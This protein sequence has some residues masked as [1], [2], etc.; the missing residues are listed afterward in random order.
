[1]IVLT[2]PQFADCIG[3]TFEAAASW[4]QHVLDAM[5]RFGITTRVRVAAFL[6][7]VGHESASLSRVE[8][9]LNYSAQR[10]M[11]VWPRRFPT[12]DRAHYFEHAPERLAN[13]VYA[14]R[15]GNAGEA[16][17]DGWR[18]RGRGPLQITGATN[19]RRCGAALTKPVW[20]YP[21]LV[22]HDQRIGAL[23]AGWVWEEHDCNECAA[24]VDEVSDRINLG[25][26]T[27]REGD[28]NGFADRKRRFEQAMEVIR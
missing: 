28:A 6:A 21:D 5:D 3:C 14:N 8:E 18:Y 24:D 19:Y 12:I 26:P 17:G 2:L 15:L 27:P 20:E 23:V 16:S 9:N 4:H 7:Q 10:L 13:Y 25:H 1:M 22:A 11:A